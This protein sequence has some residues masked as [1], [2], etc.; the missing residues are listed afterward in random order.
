[1]DFLTQVNSIGLEWYATLTGKPAA[2]PP[3]AVGTVPAPGSAAA[4]LTGNTGIIVVA[5]V[6]LIVGLVVYLLLSK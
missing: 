2:P 6:L 4:L 1:M 5:G 3:V